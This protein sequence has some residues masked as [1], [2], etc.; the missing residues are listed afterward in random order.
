MGR[1]EKTMKLWSI[2]NPSSPVHIFNGHSEPISSFDW[3]VRGSLKT[4]TQSFY[5]LVSLGKDSTINIWNVSKSLQDGCKFGFHANEHGSM[6][7]KRS[8]SISEREMENERTKEI[9]PEL[10]EAEKKDDFTSESP[11]V[12][13]TIPISGLTDEGPSLDLSQ[14][15]LNTQEKMKGSV[16]SHSLSPSSQTLWA[17]IICSS[18]GMMELEIEE[19]DPVNRCC[20]VALYDCPLHEVD[21]T[22]CT[23]SCSQSPSV[24]W[25][26]L[27][28]GS[29]I[30]VTNPL[31]PWYSKQFAEGR[32]KKHHYKNQ[33]QLPQLLSSC[34]ALIS[35]LAWYYCRSG[36]HTNY[37]TGIKITNLSF[38]L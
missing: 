12:P 9:S 5:G 18:A 30:L 23:H 15:L 14:E 38:F 7:R 29:K 4:S 21:Q 25:P 11:S 13:P 2:F 6:G 10:D 37:Q 17:N 35:L 33:D 1:G 34:S 19:A 3:R 31:P 20:L 22:E 27:Y 36:T 32:W 24:P 26:F 28:E 16:L 8:T